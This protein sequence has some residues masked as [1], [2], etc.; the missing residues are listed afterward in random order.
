MQEAGGYYLF[1]LRLIPAVPFFVINLVMGIMP[2]SVWRF[3]WISQLGMLPGTIVY[4]NAGTQLGSLQSVGE[5]LSLDLLLSF[6]LLACFPWFASACLGILERRRLYKRFDKPKYFDV[7]LLVIGGGAA[8]LVSAYIAAAVKAKVAL[9]EKHR[10]GGDCLNYG[11]VP[12]KSLIQM[13]KV[14][15]E[16]KRGNAFGLSISN[17]QLNFKQ[18]METVQTRITAIEPHDSRQRY[19]ALGVECLEGEAQIITPYLVQVGERKLRCRNIVV[20]TGAAP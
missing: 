2:V 13:A 18:L 20:A 19:T 7:N 4:V 5:I 14:V 15:H 11:C 10:M 3:Y 16:A 17:L 1:S 6:A 9:V 8:G 12:S